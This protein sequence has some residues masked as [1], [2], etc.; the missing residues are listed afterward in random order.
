MQGTAMV[1]Y[2]ER[3]SAESAQAL[4]TAFRDEIQV[5]FPVSPVFY[6]FRRT[7]IYAQK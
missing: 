1:P 2:L 7:L 3:R 4:L 6:G 5:A